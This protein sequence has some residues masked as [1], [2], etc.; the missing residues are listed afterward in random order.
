MRIGQ[1]A[2]RCG[3]TSTAIR[4]YESIGV[5]V[6]PVRTASGY[7]EYSEDAIERLRFVR[8]AQAAGLTLDEVQSILRLKDAGARSCDHTVALLERHIGDI[9]RQIERLAVARRDLEELAE[10]ARQL[11]PGACTDPNRCQVIDA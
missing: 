9:D 8:D 4:Y 5:L 2:D 6:E 3:V 7:R 1:L 10:R 11:D